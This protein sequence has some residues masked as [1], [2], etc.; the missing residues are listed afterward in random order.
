MENIRTVEGE[1]NA[2]GLKFAI[3][4]GRF[5]N[6]VVDHLVSGAIDAIIRHGG[7]SADIVLVRVPGSYEIPQICRK[8]A[9]GGR[10]DAL[11]AV[12]AVIRGHTPHF[13]LV[14][15]EV[16]KGIAQVTLQHD[17]P[18]GFGIITADNLEQAIERSGTKSGNKGAD[19]ALAALEM[20][21]V[22][23]GLKRAKI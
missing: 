12:G 21:N 23:K 8:L 15:A 22:I 14:A 16:A 9:E 6:F 17:T 4:A 7:K 1:L 18:I 3:V 19:A 11:V 5:N 20:A 13:D 2:S 10:F